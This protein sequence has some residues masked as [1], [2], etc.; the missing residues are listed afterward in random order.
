MIKL[1]V[2]HNVYDNQNHDYLKGE[3]GVIR[4]FGDCLVQSLEW[5]KENNEREKKYFD[6]CDDINIGMNRLLEKTD[7]EKIV[8]LLGDKEKLTYAIECTF[9]EI[10]EQFI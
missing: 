8:D 4:R 7:N 3:D 6:L 2:Q 5:I 1:S 10:M 9:D